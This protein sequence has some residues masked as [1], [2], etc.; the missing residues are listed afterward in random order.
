MKITSISRKLLS[1][2]LSVYFIL[3]FSVTGIQIIAEY[4]NTK[5]H[6]NSELLTLQK[7]I[8]GSLTRAV[9]ELNT[10]QAIDIS[11]GLIAI[12]MIKGI[13]VTDEANKVITQLGEVLTL[14]STAQESY[15]E[16]QSISSISEGLFGHSFPLIFE[17]SG[18]TT[19]VGTVT[20]LSSNDVIFGRIEVGIYFL[21][22]N[23]IVKTAFLIFLFSLAFTKL[24][25]E[26]LQELTDQMKQLDL[27][28]PEASK[29]HSMNNERNELN[30]L[31]DAYNNLID[32]LVAFKDKLALSQRETNLANDK[33]DEQNLLLEQEVARKTSTLSR[34]LLRME[35]QQKDMLAQQHQLKAENNR[36]RKTETTLITTNKDL[37][38]S[39][40]ELSRAQDRL[41]EAEKMASLGLLSAEVSHEIN[42]P[43]GISIT[44]ASYLSDIIH[45]FQQDINAQK[46]SKRTIDS[47]IDNAGQCVE[48]LSNNLQRAAELITSFKQ[49]AVD[50]TNDK[51]RLINVAKYLDEIIHSIHPK[52]KKTNH[53]IK[54]HCDPH[55]EIYTHPGA[56]AQ[57]IINLII[58][59]ISH[60]F[61]NINRGEMTIDIAVEQQRLVILY[62]DNGV[63]VNEQQLERIFEPFYTTQANNGGTGL[64]THIIKNLV[65]DTLNGSIDVYSAEGKGLRYRITFPDMRYS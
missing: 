44:S 5:S 16:H 40:I 27:H 29:F 39:I 54:V 2:V 37:K 9:W 11:E 32:E 35:V 21:I 55:I 48:L 45:K 61:P 59:S 38:I 23:A 63:G 58:N 64:G 52:L 60:G 42:T 57:I 13:T 36:R 26:P 43:I 12:P 25:T 31:E 30:V 19:T 33:L 51:V 3:T 41:L 46:L 20:L 17:F 50:Q 65:I 53:S 62:R 18:R 6:I 34:T 1:K 7:T 24:L 8:S 10:Q 15:S 28:D 49:V 4:F 14:S 22:G 47:F 56:I